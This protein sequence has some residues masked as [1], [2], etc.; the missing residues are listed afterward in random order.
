MPIKGDIRIGRPIESGARDATAK[1]SV[2]VTFL[3]AMGD[4]ND[5]LLTFPHVCVGGFVTFANTCCIFGVQI[6]HIFIFLSV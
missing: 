6:N 5:L 2:V 1:M 3:G 4:V